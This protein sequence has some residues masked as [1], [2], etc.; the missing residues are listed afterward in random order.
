M[1]SS[2]NMSCMFQCVQIPVQGDGHVFNLTLC[3]NTCSTCKYLY[4]VLRINSIFVFS[5]SQDH[6]D[7][8]Q[9]SHKGDRCVFIPQPCHK[10]MCKINFISQQLNFLLCI[11]ESFTACGITKKF[12]LVGNKITN[13]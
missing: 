3:I 11:F 1:S 6:V 9:F 2:S 10:N 8:I 5:Y 13:Y 12:P 4:C 7:S